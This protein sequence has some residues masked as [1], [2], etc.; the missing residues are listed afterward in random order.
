MA[1]SNCGTFAAVGSAGGII[2]IYNLQSGQ[3]RQRF[4]PSPS[5]K[6]KFGK[7]AGHIKAVTG[8]AIDNL[9]RNVVSCGLDGKLKVCCKY[10][11]I[12][13]HYTNMISSGISTPGIFLPT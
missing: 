8:L 4:P 7:V 9:N 1:I 3:R 12:A 2:D 11:S 6:N 5:S 10:I 13:F